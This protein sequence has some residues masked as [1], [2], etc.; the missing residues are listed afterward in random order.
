M[1][2]DPSNKHIQI[3]IET[4]LVGNQLWKVLK[5]SIVVMFA[6]NTLQDISSGTFFSNLFPIK[7]M[8]VKE[9]RKASHILKKHSTFNLRIFYFL[10]FIFPQ[11]GDECR[12]KGLWFTSNLLLLTQ[13]STSSNVLALDKARDQIMW[14]ISKRKILSTEISHYRCA[15]IIFR[16]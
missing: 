2:N 13:R 10:F 9:I 11:E 15:T 3:I 5:T 14:T 1:W 6:T 4:Q 7:I 16:V 12:S 8:G